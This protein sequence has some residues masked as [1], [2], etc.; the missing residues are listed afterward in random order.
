[1]TGPAG[2][3]DELRVGSLEKASIAENVVL[4]LS[5]KKGELVFEWNMPA[6]AA[7]IELV[8]AG[9]IGSVPNTS[10]VNE[11]SP[12]KLVVLDPTPM[13]ESALDSA[14][15]ILA[16]RTRPLRPSKAVAAVRHEVT[17]AVYSALE[18][19]G[20]A[21]AVGNFPSRGHLRIDDDEGFAF[22]RDR[23][24]LIRSRP[25]LVTDARTG[26]FIDVLR[27]G[28]PSYAG[29]NGL[30][31]RIRW[32]WYPQDVRETIDAILM[33]EQILFTSD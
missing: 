4:M 11:A 14:L 22:E 23:L 3:G 20:M 17:L 33:A 21:H 24:A 27:N 7:L 2:M 28:A 29:E 25:D 9:R 8:L 5:T 32:E 13:G 6:V 30:H 26:A 18:G 16:S 19:R 10:F 31:P 15:G 1:M 12:R